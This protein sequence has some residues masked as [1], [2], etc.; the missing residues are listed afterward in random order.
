MYVSPG[1]VSNEILGVVGDLG[2]MER[3]M[4]FNSET[5]LVLVTSLAF[6]IPAFASW[7][8]A[9]IW[10]AW[11]FGMMTVV[12][13]SYHFCS[14]DVALAHGA[15][16]AARCSSTSTHFLT[17]AFIICVHFCFVQMAFLVIGPEDPHMQCIGCQAGTLKEGVMNVFGGGPGRMPLHSI[18]VSRVAPAA[19]LVAFHVLHAS[20]GSEEIHWKSLLLN[21]ALLLACSA[22]FWA[23]PSR[24]GHAADV[25][26]RFKY[27]HRLLHHGLIP[28]MMLFWIFCMMSFADFQAL[29]SLWHVVVAVFAVSL[30]RTVL[31]GEEVSS[32]SAKA[33]EHPYHNPNVAHVLLGS[34]ALVVLP[35]AVIGSSFDWCS[36]GERRWPTL[37]SATRCQPGG[38]FAAIVAVPAFACVA[39]VFWLID[40]TA[41]TTT[42]WLQFHTAKP[43]DDREPSLD[44]QQLALGKRL[45]CLLGYGGAGAGLLAALVM[46]G[47]PIQNVM[48]LFFSVTSLGLIMVA[49][50]LTVVSSDPSAQNFRF[51]WVLT[52]AV[53]LPVT[54]L[55]MVL[56]L[57]DQCLPTVYE[58][59]RPVY[60]TTEY[61]AIAL[62]CLW[63][64]SWSTEVQETWQRNASGKFAWPV[65]PWRFVP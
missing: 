28:A 53:C 2:A 14:A 49:M 26:L 40:S 63:P 5:A 20:W 27:W 21:E 45:G 41:S 30:L 58:V 37:S 36:T 4:N 46:R 57:A 17:H 39:T 18:I 31:L 43:W 33:V 51:R 38:Y 13:T 24:E 25:L 52:M 15:R 19:V 8:M 62:L 60:A 10:H 59:P 29:H 23:H 35:T 7:R 1:S 16:S 65:T 56:V 6:L 55:H 12:C 61:A 34:V 50:V 11:L 64:L 47:S 22:A 3:A 9:R 54:V 42:L 44:P 48:N 32:P